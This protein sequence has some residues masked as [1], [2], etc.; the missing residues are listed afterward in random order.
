MRNDSRKGSDAMELAFVLVEPAR[1]EHVGVAARALK[2]LA[3]A[4][5]R[6]VATDAHRDPRA[7]WAA[8]GAT[9]I[10]DAAEVFESFEEATA[11]LS[12]V[13][14][15]T[16]RRRGFTGRYYRP[17]ELSELLRSKSRVVERA[18]IV[19]GPEERGLR[20]S[21]LRRCDVLTSVA[22]RQE[23]PSLNLSQAVT[24]YAY[25]LSGAAHRRRSRTTASA[26]GTQ[27]ALQA[28]LRELLAWLEI[29]PESPLYRSAQERT[30]VLHDNDTELLLGLLNKLMMRL[31]AE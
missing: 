16:A 15:T 10:L 5:L 28:R 21:E 31:P 24:V 23:Q 6:L 27:A 30:T 18:G 26:P 29:A 7:V 8:H 12:F 9:D 2:A 11:D 3:A 20:N 22:L 25:E 14:G 1:P 19:F 4:D 17:R 13:A